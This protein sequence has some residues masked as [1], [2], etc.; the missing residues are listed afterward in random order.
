VPAG[1]LI[2]TQD[3]AA[4][5]GVLSVTLGNDDLTALGK[6]ISFIY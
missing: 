4:V 1:T 3:Q 2:L 5:E 6:L